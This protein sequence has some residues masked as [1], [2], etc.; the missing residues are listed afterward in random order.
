ML[1]VTVVSLAVMLAGP[2]GMFE[3]DPRIDFPNVTTVTSCGLVQ[4]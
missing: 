1:V 4:G 3:V 2:K